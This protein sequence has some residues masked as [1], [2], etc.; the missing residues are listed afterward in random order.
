MIKAAGL[1]PAA[2]RMRNLLYDI[3]FSGTTGTKR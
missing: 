1:V 2:F 3:Y